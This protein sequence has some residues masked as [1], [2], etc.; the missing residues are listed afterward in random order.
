M[1]E[2]SL[3]VP[4]I[5]FIS[6]PFHLL[7]EQNVVVKTFSQLDMRKRYFTPWIDFLEAITS[8]ISRSCIAAE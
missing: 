7:Q 5:A 6:P 3:A 1:S 8:L 2:I 4:V